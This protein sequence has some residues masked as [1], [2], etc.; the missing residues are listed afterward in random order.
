MRIVDHTIQLRLLPVLL[1]TL[2]INRPRLQDTGQVGCLLDLLAVG[3]RTL[4]LERREHF[5]D[6]LR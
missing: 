2:K 1:R 3:R 5:I 6:P 4:R